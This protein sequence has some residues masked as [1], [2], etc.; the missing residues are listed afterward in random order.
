MFDNKSFTSNILQNKPTRQR[1]MP[2]SPPSSHWWWRHCTGM[3]RTTT[4]TPEIQICIITEQL[5]VKRLHLFN[6]F[7]RRMIKN[8]QD[9]LQTSSKIKRPINGINL[10]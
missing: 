8:M 1:S 3:I 10:V 6:I 2:V 5:C 9:V 7:I 4:L